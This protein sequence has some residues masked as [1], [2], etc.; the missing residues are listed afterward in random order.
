[1]GGG[2]REVSTAKAYLGL[3]VSICLTLHCVVMKLA[4]GERKEEKRVKWNVGEIFGMEVGK[5]KMAAKK[6]KA[7]MGKM[8]Q[9]S[10]C[11]IRSE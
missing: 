8:D 10:N 2:V 9:D 1:M 3:V 6:M 5:K 7:S 11:C 4:Y